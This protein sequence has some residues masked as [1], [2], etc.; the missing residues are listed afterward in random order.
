MCTF[1]HRYTVLGNRKASCSG[2]PVSQESWGTISEIL[3]AEMMVLLV[4]LCPFYDAAIGVQRAHALG[5]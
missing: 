5:R 2:T 1:K 3:H 4:F